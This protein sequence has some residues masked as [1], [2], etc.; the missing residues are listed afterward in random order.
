MPREFDIERADVADAFDMNFLRLNPEAMRE[1]R[2][3][4]DLVLRIPAIDVEVRRRFGVTWAYGSILFWPARRWRRNV[5]P[6]VS[7]NRLER[8]SVPRI[9]PRW[10][11][12]SRYS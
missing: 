5:L 6:A 4:A 12:N 3:N 11:R 1:R 2:E 7:I 10:R 8:W 9:M